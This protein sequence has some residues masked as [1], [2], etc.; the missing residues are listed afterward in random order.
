MLQRTDLTRISAV[1]LLTT[2]VA[3]SAFAQKFSPENLGPSIPP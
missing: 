2:V 1:A 3:A